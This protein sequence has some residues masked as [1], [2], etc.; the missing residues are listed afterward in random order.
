MKYRRIRI[1]GTSYFFTL[2]LQNRKSDLLVQN[3]D[4]LRSAFKKVQ[5]NHPFII[6]A[7]VILPDHLHVLIT[8][9]LHDNDYATRLNL[10]KGNFSRQIKHNEKISASRK[11]KRERGI[12][13]R[14]FWEHCIRCDS[15]YENHINYIHYNPVKHNYVTV[16]SKWP[17]SS[18]HRFIRLNLLPINWG[19][20]LVVQPI[21]Y[22]E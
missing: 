10:I 7:V 17:Y 3:I 2:T 1:S 11:N 19:A 15:D 16:P 14:R 4:A 13:Q 12:W 6:D 5:L 21:S 9:P 18:I 22:G 8:L 20:G